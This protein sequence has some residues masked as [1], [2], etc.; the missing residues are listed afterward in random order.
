MKFDP[1]AEGSPRIEEI[2]AQIAELEERRRVAIERREAEREAIE[3]ASEPRATF[4]FGPADWVQSPDAEVQ[5]D[6]VPVEQ[7]RDVPADDRD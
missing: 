7:P 6:N 3:M 1:T 2:D 4:P 5:L